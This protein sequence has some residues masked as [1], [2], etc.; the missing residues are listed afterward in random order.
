MNDSSIII[1]L[2]TKKHRI[3]VYKAVL[4]ALGTPTHIQFLVNPET[5][6]IAVRG[7]INPKTKDIYFCHK[8]PEGLFGSSN[9]FEVY[10]EPLISQICSL[11]CGIKEDCSYNLFG[12]IAH[13]KPIVIFPF[14][15]IK[16]IEH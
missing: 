3:R 15:N 5:G 11:I 4:Q 10:S 2:D 13:N 12:K 16:E 7:I 8:V 1:S 6:V 14:C 9:C